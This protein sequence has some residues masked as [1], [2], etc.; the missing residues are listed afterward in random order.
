MHASEGAAGNISLY[1]G[2]PLEVRRRFP[3]AEPIPLPQPVP[4]LAGHMFIVTGSGRRLRD[5]PLDGISQPITLSV[6]AGVASIADTGN[7][8][9]ALYRAADSA[10]YAAKRSGRNTCCLADSPP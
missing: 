4:E 8:Y 10:L 5:I 2:W 6:S 3:V 7:A 9:E 1:V